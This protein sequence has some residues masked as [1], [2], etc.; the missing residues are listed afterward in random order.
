MRDNLQFRE[1]IHLGG[2]IADSN[3]TPIP[4][5]DPDISSDSTNFKNRAEFHPHMD[6]TPPN[7]H[8]FRDH[9]VQLRCDQAVRQDAGDGVC[10]GAVYEWGNVVDPMVPAARLYPGKC[11]YG[12]GQREI[13]VQVDVC[14]DKEFVA[15][16]DRRF[17][18]C[19]WDRV[20]I[21]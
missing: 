9:R 15:A 16:K 20:R 13:E 19:G 1:D 4:Q 18:G 11:Q 21:G 10:H 12:G 8:I 5:S 3:E 17:R 2:K 7:D 14:L 6:L